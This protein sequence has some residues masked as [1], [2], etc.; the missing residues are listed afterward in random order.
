[1]PSSTIYQEIA[2]FDLQGFI[3]G[4]TEEEKVVLFKKLGEGLQDR[5]ADKLWLEE[6]DSYPYSQEFMANYVSN[7][8][9]ELAESLFTNPEIG[10]ASADIV[11]TFH[12]GET[13]QV[14]TIIY[15]SEIPYEYLLKKTMELNNIDPSMVKEHLFVG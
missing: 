14:V 7:R 3:D 5:E 6:H 8:Y 9:V 1:M 2:D 13:K 11:F 15:T 10:T 12:N 4:L